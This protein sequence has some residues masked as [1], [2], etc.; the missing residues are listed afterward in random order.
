[1]IK[2]IPLQPDGCKLLKFVFLCVQ[3]SEQIY[4]LIIV[5]FI[6]LLF[7]SL[8]SLTEVNTTKC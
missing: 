1:M 6:L 3:K 7:I 4:F 2:N 5:L 8:F